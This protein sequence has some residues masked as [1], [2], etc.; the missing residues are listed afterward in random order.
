MWYSTEQELNNAGYYL[1]EK[2]IQELYV[3]P[4]DWQSWYYD[5]RVTRNS[6]SFRLT[7]N[8]IMNL[9]L[10]NERTQPF[11]YDGKNWKFDIGETAKY[12]TFSNPV[13]ALD[14]MPT[15][16]TSGN[17]RYTLLSV[18]TQSGNP[19][20]PLVQ[21]DLGLQM[22]GH[23]STNY[24][25]DLSTTTNFKIVVSYWKYVDKVLSF[26]NTQLP[27]III[28]LPQSIIAESGST[29]TLP[30]M[31]GEYESGGKMWKP[32]AWDIGAFGSSYTLNMDTVAHLIF[33]TEI[34]IYASVGTPV[35]I[36]DGYIVQ[37]VYCEALFIKADSVTRTDQTHISFSFNG[38]GLYCDDTDLSLFGV[39]V[40]PCLQVFTLQNNTYTGFYISVRS[41]FT[42]TNIPTSSAAT[43]MNTNGVFLQGTAQA[44]FA[45]INS[46]DSQLRTRPTW[47]SRTD[48]N[49]NRIPYY[50]RMSSSLWQVQS[51]TLTWLGDTTDDTTPAYWY[52]SQGVRIHCV[53]FS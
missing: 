11:L 52:N 25:S 20:S 29:I 4:Y 9:W 6:T 21:S 49:N 31:T 48:E 47:F 22:R 35:T 45:I 40:T 46:L 19:I 15:S 23:L 51:G 10:D 32:S 13:F 5:Y 18:I 43:E 1:T 53:K 24:Y 41:S 3:G 34:D 16:T 12:K 17:D 42:G 44:S 38:E 39:K 2:V 36:P 26:A 8:Y 14:Q 7:G 27:D 33:K 30:T 50:F 28:D 37:N